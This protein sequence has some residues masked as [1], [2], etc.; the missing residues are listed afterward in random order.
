MA[1][2]RS[3]VVSIAREI[4]GTFKRTA[5]LPVIYELNDFSVSVFDDR[6]NLIGD[7]PGLPEFVGSLDFALRS[8]AGE[9][10]GDNPLV[11]GDIVIVNDPFTT[12]AHTS[13][14]SIIV[15]AFFGDTLIGYT[16]IRAH[17][18]DMGAK[19][20]Y[21]CDSQSM[22]EEG[23]IL[24]PVRLY[25]AGKMDPKLHAIISANSRAPR[26]T[27]GNIVAAGQALAS[28]A[29]RLTGLVEK[30]GIDVYHA[31]ID[32]LM[33]Q[34]EREV[35]QAINLVPD[36]I[37]QHEDYFDDNGVTDGRVLLRVT[38]TVSGS[39]MT[40][41]TSGSA[42]QQLGPINSTLPA[43][44]AACRLALKRLTTQSSLPTNSG[45]SRPLTVVAPSG[46]IFNPDA[47]A[48]TYLMGWSGGRLGDMIVQAVASAHPHLFPAQSGGDA[49]VVI[50]SHEDS[51]TGRVTFFADSPPQGFGAAAQADGMDALLHA[52]VAG[53]ELTSA[54]IWETRMPI[55]KISTSLVMDSGGP[56]RWRGGLGTRTE[57]EFLGDVELTLFAEKTVASMARGVGGGLPSSVRNSITI[58][59]G[60]DNAKDVGKVGAARLIA[61]DR[62]AFVGGGGG[63]N[64]AAHL[65]DPELVLH[66]VMTHAVSS[67][68]ARED[69]AVVVTSDPLAIDWDATRRL[70]DEIA[71]AAPKLGLT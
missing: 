59:P 26:E 27:F 1:V 50:G 51:T 21:P 48:P 62:V 60:S 19:D 44:T 49:V 2:V 20:S 66:D 68:S 22:F 34:S 69:Y 29:R 32:Q 54:E 15:P 33:D 57:W 8:V 56:G 46:S 13:D 37:Y 64:G 36:G 18:G 7:A 24:P 10:A 45:D 42:G 28:G 55:R 40:I 25:E 14:V 41:D 31:A 6:L 65:R 67:G 58:N 23:L 71:A 47:P 38:V 39:Q 43:T 9:F 11:P 70:R 5:L 12:G 17:V 35:R 3:S 63:G 16:G 4:F 30:Y 61:G 52:P 53:S